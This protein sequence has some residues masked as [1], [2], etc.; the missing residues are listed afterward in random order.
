MMSK[1]IKK[2]KKFEDINI[3]FEDLHNKKPV[4]RRDFLATGIIPF[5]A[6][7]LTP[8]LLNLLTPGNAFAN[9]SRCE[10][11]AASADFPAFINVNLAGGSGLSSHAIGLDEGGQLLEKYTRM[12]LGLSSRLNTVERFGGSVWYQNSTFLRGLETEMSASTMANTAFVNLCVESRDDSAENP[13]DISGLVDRVRSG[14]LLPTLNPNRNKPALL[15]PK[16]SVAVG[17]LTDLRSSILLSGNLNNL[18]N[19]SEKGKLLN[20][21]NNLSTSQMQ[22]VQNQ[23]YGDQIQNLLSCAGIKNADL[24]SKADLGIDPSADLNVASLW[25]IDQMENAGG[26]NF[27][28]AAIA[29][30]TLKGNSTLGNITLGGYDYHNGTRTN[31][32]DRD[33]AA[34]ARV[35][36]LLETAA[37]MGQKLFLT[38]TSDGSVTSG[39]S[40]NP[41]EAPWNSDGGTRGMMYMFAFD[42]TGRPGLKGKQLGSFTQGQA[43]NDK[44]LVGGSPELAAAAVFANYLSFAGKLSKF[45]EVVG[46]GTLDSVELDEVSLILG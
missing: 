31:G 40:E 39:D 12:G 34:G 45:E 16:P 41:G 30:N 3:K 6:S 9:A 5:A 13:I 27:V 28:S 21:V 19:D 8:N 42:P 26:Q 14:S 11:G 36:R 2:N 25:G 44:T 22:K 17:G 46:R 1:N 33:E 18:L 43:V 7:V 29:Y 4:T 38:V 23:T 24:V 20:L 37:I 35:G 32:D 15:V 10:S